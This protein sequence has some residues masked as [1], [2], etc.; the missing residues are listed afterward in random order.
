MNLS[1]PTDSAVDVAATA[2]VTH[3]ADYVRAVT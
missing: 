1:L 3:T 2:A